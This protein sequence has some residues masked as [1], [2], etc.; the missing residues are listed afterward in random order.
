MAKKASGFILIYVIGILIFL[1]IVGL[2][3]AYTLRINAQLVVNE[4][5]ELQNEQI[6]KSAVQYTQAQLIKGRLAEPVLK[7]LDPALNAGTVLWKLGGGPYLIR[8]QEANIE[9]AL[10]DAGDLPDVNALTKEE[11]QRIFRALG[12]AENESA[13]LAGVLVKAREMAS[14]ARG[15]PGFETIQ[16][17]LDLDGLPYRYRYGVKREAGNEGQSQGEPPQ[18]GLAQW[19][20]VGTGTKTIS[21][22]QAPLPI[23]GVLA[24]AEPSSLARFDAARKA[25]ALTLAEAVQILGPSASP[26]LREGASSIYRIRLKMERFGRV[27]G[28]IALTREEGGAFKVISYR[29]TQPGN[30]Q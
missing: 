28:A 4:K 8:V 7:T 3:I 29:N 24:N 1:G 14:A 5:E 17:V 11:I 6:L 18:I 21:L 2:G 26:V 19:V 16:Q 9:V 23:V 12:A 10:E 15:G 22:N 30:E 20:T 13:T 27:Y 25:K